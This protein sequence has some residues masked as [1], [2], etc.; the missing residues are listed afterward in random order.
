MHTNVKSNVL[1][2][3]AT[4]K[5]TF[6]FTLSST[7]FTPTPAMTALVPRHFRLVHCG[8]F[9]GIIWPKLKFSFINF[10]YISYS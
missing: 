3:V 8:L 4:H 5:N 1:L 2:A 10:Y 7:C 9:R 6:Q